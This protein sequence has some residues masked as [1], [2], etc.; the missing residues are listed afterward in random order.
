METKELKRVLQTIR[1]ALSS[2]EV[3]PALSCF[4]FDEDC[5]YAYNNWMCIAVPLDTGLQFGTMGESLYRLVNSLSSKEVDLYL[6]D[7][8]Q[9]VVQGGRSSYKASVIDPDRF[10]LDTKSLKVA[11]K[12][13]IRIPITESFLEGLEKCLMSVGGDIVAMPQYAG[14]QVKASKGKVSICSTDSVSLSKYT[15]IVRGASNF[16]TVLL[17]QEFCSQLLALKAWLKKAE[18]VVSN[19]VVGVAVPDV[20][21][22]ERYLMFSKL[23]YKGD[24]PDFDATIK[25]HTGGEEV[26]IKIP[27]SLVNA[28][29]RASVVLGSSSDKITKISS[30]GKGGKLV[31][32]TSNPS[33]E[34]VDTVVVKAAKLPKFVKPTRTA[35]TL[36]ACKATEEL[37]FGDKAIFYS[38][39]GGNFFH[40]VAYARGE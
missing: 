21:D 36:R 30:P 5:V 16:D 40:M 2:D 20:F 31:L 10:V 3:I 11:K 28:L 32:T 15:C 34:T 13:A 1:P 39:A 29:D 19:T 38:S 37:C 33:G 12:G 18:L 26:W 35:I 17:P 22:G 27:P 14:L 8:E 23:L 7:D 25:N 24:L 6:N 4:C 9:L